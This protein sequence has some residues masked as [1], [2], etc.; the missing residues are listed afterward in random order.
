[1]PPATGSEARDA[2]DDQRQEQESAGDDKQRPDR[3]DLASE[4]YRKGRDCEADGSDQQKAG[5]RGN[6]DAPSCRPDFRLDR[7]EPDRAE[8]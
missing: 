7:R 8:E 2:L 4:P 1:M 5:D 6:R 3:P